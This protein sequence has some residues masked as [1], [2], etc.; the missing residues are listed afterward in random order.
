MESGVEMF[1]VV[2]PSFSALCHFLIFGR[3]ENP[4]QRM[5]EDRDNFVA[6]IPARICS[7]PYQHLRPDSMDIMTDRRARC[8][9]LCGWLGFHL[10]AH[11]IRPLD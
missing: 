4:A 7:S 9:D 2:R 5:A 10:R 3:A 6:G 8:Q 11:R 1:I